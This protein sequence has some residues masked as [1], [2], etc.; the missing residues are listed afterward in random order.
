MNIVMNFVNK[1]FPSTQSKLML[2]SGLVVLFVAL[3]K[4]KKPLILTLFT[5]PFILIQAYI[6]NCIVAGDC[7]KIGWLYVIMNIS[8]AFTAL[9]TLM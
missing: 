5:L 8:T 2:L 6:V 3:M 7:L 9:T 1:H 4:S